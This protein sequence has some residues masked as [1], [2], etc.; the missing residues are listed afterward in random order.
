[1]V[2]R[3]AFLLGEEFIGD[4]CCAMV[5]GDNIFY[6]N[7]FTHLLRSAVKDAENGKASIFGY[8]VRRSRSA[9]AL[10]S[11]TRRER[12]I[13]A[14]GEAG[15]PKSNYCVTGLYFYDNRWWSMPKNVKPSARGELEI[16]D[17]N[18]I[19]SGRTADLNVKLLGRGYAWLDTGTTDSLWLEAG[20]LC[21]YDSDTSRG[22]RSSSPEESGL[23]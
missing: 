14:G 3:E 23:Y 13:S 19:V 5:L 15:D 8:Y 4:D 6:G 17:L 11:L 21:A 12:A 2:W 16:T 22:W 20:Q 10:L 7:G 9:S 18:R 1:M